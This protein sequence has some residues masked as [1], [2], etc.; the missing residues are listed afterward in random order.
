[1]VEKVENNWWKGEEKDN[2]REFGGERKLDGQGNKIWRWKE[3]SLSEVMLRQK[4]GELSTLTLLL[5]D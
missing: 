5:K 3:R 4:L 1:M 2:K